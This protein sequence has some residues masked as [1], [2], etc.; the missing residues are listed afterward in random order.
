M[1]FSIRASCSGYLI[2]L[3]FNL[4]L[5]SSGLDLEGKNIKL[6]VFV[7][8]KNILRLTAS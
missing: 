3:P 7:S 8:F 2:K 4:L 5:F 6:L 1:D